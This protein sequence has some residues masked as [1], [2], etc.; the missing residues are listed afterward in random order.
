M[1]QGLD[2]AATLDIPFVFASEFMDIEDGW[3]T[4]RDRV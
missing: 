1:Q 4:R 3:S 2:Y